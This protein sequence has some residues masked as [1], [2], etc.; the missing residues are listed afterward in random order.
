[1]KGAFISGTFDSIFIRG[2]DNRIFLVVDSYDDIM[3]MPRHLSADI[4][5][6]FKK[7][8]KKNKIDE[9]FVKQ[10]ETKLK[11]ILMK[12]AISLEYSENDEWIIKNME[13]TD[14]LMKII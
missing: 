12:K 11:T 7:A 5:D 13:I 2:T 8:Y 4:T 3:E 1:V 6:E 14:I 9:D 10:I